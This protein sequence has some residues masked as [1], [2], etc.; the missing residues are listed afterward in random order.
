MTSMRQKRSAI[1]GNI[2]EQ[3]KPIGNLKYDS[4]NFKFQLKS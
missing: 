3:K 2:R 4:G 1:K